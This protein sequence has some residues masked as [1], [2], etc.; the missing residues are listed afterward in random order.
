MP[1]NNCFNENK[2]AKAQQN[3][4]NFFFNH[5][6]PKFVY[7]HSMLDIQ[8]S[9]T[10]KLFQTI[11]HDTSFLPPFFKNSGKCNFNVYFSFF[12]HFAAIRY[13]KNKCNVN[14]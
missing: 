3:V 4:T 12:F 2:A 10:K 8:I 13:L 5:S 7:F 11:D 6:P 9:T 1:N 14:F